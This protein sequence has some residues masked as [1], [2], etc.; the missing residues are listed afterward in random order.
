MLQVS[1]W[2]LKSGANRDDFGIAALNFCKN[3]K[4]NSGVSDAKF[5]W[6]NPNVIALIVEHDGSWGPN[7]EP[8]GQTMKAFFDLAD[9][10]SCTM[11]EPWIEA[12]LGHKRTQKIST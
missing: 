11:D 1:K 8:S 4:S 2:E 12:S 10:S 7:V 5:Y 3:A 9:L 6:Q